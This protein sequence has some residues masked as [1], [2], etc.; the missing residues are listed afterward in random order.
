MLPSGLPSRVPV[1]VPLIDTD[2]GLVRSLSNLRDNVL[3]A[4]P[5]QA[6]HSPVYTGRTLMRW[7]M[8]MDPVAIKRVLLDRLEDYPKSGVTKAVLGPA[9]G[10]SMFVAEGAE[11]RWQRRA[12]APAFSHRAVTALGPVMSRAAQ[13]ACDRI[14]EIGRA[15]CRERVLYTV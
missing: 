7:H 10:S 15:S 1:S 11:W 2:P 13:A 9:I 12:A 5:A 8:I 4:I 6:L 14:K 3:L